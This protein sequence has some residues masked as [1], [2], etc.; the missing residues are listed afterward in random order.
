MKDFDEHVK[1]MFYYPPKE[2]RNREPK[3]IEIDPKA[4]E[5]LVRAIFGDLKN[6]PGK[7]R[8]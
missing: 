8:G 5:C 2:K 4:T 1:N 7:P 6:P 3:K